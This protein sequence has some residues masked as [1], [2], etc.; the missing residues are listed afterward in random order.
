MKQRFHSMEA[1]VIKQYKLG[2]GTPDGKGKF[3]TN[4]EA[5]K[6]ARQRFVAKNVEIA[7]SEVRE[8]WRLKFE[9]RHVSI[10]VRLCWC[11]S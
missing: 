8:R 11:A 3:I 1:K 5:Y 2:M 9:D 10:P 6:I 7:E 4:S